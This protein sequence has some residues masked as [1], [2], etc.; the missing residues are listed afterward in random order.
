MDLVKVC[1]VCFSSDLSTVLD[2]GLHPLC[3]DLVRIGDERIAT[4]YPIRINFCR[5]CS[6]A[7]QQV[8]VPKI[9]L[10]P[11]SY[12]YRSRF[13]SDVIDGMKDLSV[14]VEKIKGSLKGKVVLDIG[15]NDGTL[16][17]I[18]KSLQ[19]VT[20]GV[21]PTDASK[22]SLQKGHDIYHEYFNK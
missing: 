8:Q 12:H 3:D 19:C 14:K 11:K 20:I 18:F 22:E 15:S 13:T 17:D 4:E 21:E 10:F 6:T 7:H 5:N 16:L 9:N 2:L 1:E